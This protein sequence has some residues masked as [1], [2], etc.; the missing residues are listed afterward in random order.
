MKYVVSVN[1]AEWD[2][3]EALCLDPIGLGGI[4]KIT[5]L[6]NSEKFSWGELIEQ[7]TLHKMMSLL[8]F[9][10]VHHIDRKKV[11]I[12]KLIFQLFEGCLSL[13]IHKTNLF[14]KE[15]ARISDLLGNNGVKFAGTKGIAYESSVYKGNGSRNFE[16]DIDFMILPEDAEKVDR[17]L[18]ENGYITG[19]YVKESNTVKPYKREKHLSYKL[20]PDHLLPRTVVTNDPLMKFLNIDFAC[21]FTWYKGEY[22]VNL[23]E[24][25]AKLHM[26]QIPGTSTLLPVLQEDYAFIFTI[27]HLFREAWFFE[28]WNKLE[29]D[30]NLMKFADVILVYKTFFPEGNLDSLREKIEMYKITEPFFWVCKHLDKTFNLSITEALQLK[31]SK[32][33]SFLNSAYLNSNE[34]MHWKGSMKERLFR[35]EKG[36]LFATSHA[37]EKM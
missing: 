9:N 33:D 24:A 20:Y 27:L 1:G 6:L 2:I 15:A 25:F 36:K 11:F 30:V 34:V 10:I 26:Q 22:D 28:K 19:D 31:S 12:P 3:L 7:A 13:N 18:I 29:Q 37:D 32:D 17:L 14:R 8:A 5:W 4:E 35:K 23:N 16:G 21:S